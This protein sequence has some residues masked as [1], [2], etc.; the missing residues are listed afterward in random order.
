M[1]SWF[2]KKQR[3]LRSTASAPM[4]IVALMSVTILILAACATGDQGSQGAKGPQGDVGAAGPQGGP[5]SQGPAGVSGSDGPNGKTGA[6]GPQGDSGDKAT[7][8]A[9]SVKLS[10]SPILV[11]GDFTLHGSGFTPGSSVTVT[12]LENGKESTPPRI[13]SPTSLAVNSSGTF[14]N[15]W[16]ARSNSKPGYYTIFVSDASGNKASAPLGIVL[17]K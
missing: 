8:S 16:S 3:N 7:S 12:I 14:T 9:P 15:V 10:P 13:S 2:R 5:G 6:K 4:S 17:T 11:G 1:S